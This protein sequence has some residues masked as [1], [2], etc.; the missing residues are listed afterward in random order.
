MIQP[1]PALP[2]QL[3]SAF[4]GQATPLGRAPGKSFGEIAQELLGQI[5]NE[6]AAPSGGQ[7][8]SRMGQPVVAALQQPFV[9][10]A[11][12]SLTPP[13]QQP[14][15]KATGPSLTS[16]V[17]QPFDKTAG[18]SLASTVEQVAGQTTAK[19]LPTTPDPLVG[20]AALKPAN[21]AGQVFE[22]ASGQTA[23][24]PAEEMAAASAGKVIEGPSAAAPCLMRFVTNGSS[25]SFEMAGP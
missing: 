6:P 8:P 7:L 24:E 21:T 20:K 11:G 5:A 3:G 25:T 17:E 16:T 2:I 13:A 1:V 10:V 12:Y 9:K 19:N 15:V 18:S 14:V 4:T 22:Q 23:A